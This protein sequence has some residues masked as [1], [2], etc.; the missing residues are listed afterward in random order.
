MP[1][2]AI[3]LDQLS[4]V[5]LGVRRP[6][7]VVVSKD[8]RVWLSD[9]N[10]AAAEVLPDGTLNRVGAAGGSPNGINM[11]A[12][13]RILIANVGGLDGESADTPAVGGGGPL[14]RLDVE[15]GEIE[16]LASEVDGRPLLSSNYPIVD[17]AG[18]IYCS[19]STSSNGTDAFDGRKDGF[20]FR[21]NLDGSAELLAD[22][23]Q[24]ANGLALDA[25]EAHVYVCQTTGCNVVRYAINA[26]GSLGPAEEYGPKLGITAAEVQDERPLSPET[27]G[28]LGLTDGCGFDQDGNLWVTLPM[29]NKVVAITPGGDVETMIEDLEGKIMRAP[30]NV[31][32]G[33]D[34]MRD[35]YVGSI[36]TDYVIKARSP[37][38]GMPLIHQR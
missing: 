36:V 9:Q 18:N 16:V 6:E 19:H 38:P 20:L 27:R 15:T 25:D 7:D 12:Q 26:D 31:S 11:D 17:S 13:G 29:S 34:G 23:I 14:Q 24:F 8:G 28:K 22:E 32:W 2:Q 3:P 4:K 30:T 21:L 37:V 1:L 5:G 35:L 10:S 33:G